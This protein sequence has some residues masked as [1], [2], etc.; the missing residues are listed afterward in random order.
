MKKQPHITEKTKG[1]IIDV[2]C[3]LY[4]EKP[5]EKITIREIT[6]KSGYNRSTFYQYFD[7]IYDL[8]DTI[9]N[10]VLQT[11]SSIVVSDL[12]PEE[13][14]DLTVHKL[15]RLFSEKEKYLSALLGTYGSVRFINKLKNEVENDVIDVEL[16]DNLIEPYETSIIFPFIR[17]YFLSTALSLFTYWSKHKTLTT[18]ELIFLISKLIDNGVGSEVRELFI[19]TRT[20]S[21]SNK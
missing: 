8:L 6:K 5:I 2:F 3:E 15:A 1:K 21:L 16:P 9:E 13:N 20:E 11:F 4:M 7:D 19:K 17:E 12:K 10:D 14:W 18:E